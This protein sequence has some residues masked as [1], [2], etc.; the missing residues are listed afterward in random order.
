MNSLWGESLPVSCKHPLSK[1]VETV[2]RFS[3]V[4]DQAQFSAVNWSKKQPEESR[5]SLPFFLLYF[6]ALLDFPSPPLSAPGSP[7]MESPGA[8]G[9][10]VGSE[11]V[12]TGNK[13]YD[14]LNKCYMTT[15]TNRQ[16]GGQTCCN[17]AGNRHYEISRDQ[18]KQFKPNLYFQTAPLYPAV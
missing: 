1:G 16:D 9:V 15:L 11:R 14:T 3:G 7:R 6:S 2:S 17:L 10:A 12:K 18:H 4:F 13:F 8:P 5:R